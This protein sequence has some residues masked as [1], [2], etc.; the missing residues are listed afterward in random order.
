MSEE[1][2][3]MPH[4]GKPPA[5]FKLAESR[6][7]NQ[8]QMNFIFEFYPQYQNEQDFTKIFDYFE[9]ESQQL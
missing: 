7:P 5:F 8:D 3:K 1:E 2:N 6:V 9:Q 4:K